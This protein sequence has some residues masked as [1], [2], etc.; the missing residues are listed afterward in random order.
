M[1]EILQV[2]LDQQLEVKPQQMKE[3][4]EE[5]VIVKLYTL[6]EKEEQVQ[7]QRLLEEITLTEIQRH[8]G[9]TLEEVQG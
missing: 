6:E 1:T 5:E 2:S 3:Q 8:Q 9:Q 4:L 7:V